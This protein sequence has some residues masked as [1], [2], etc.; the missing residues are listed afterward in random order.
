VWRLLVALM[1]CGC[2]RV[3]F[4]ARDDAGTRDTPL[5]DIPTDALDP[6]LVLWF[7]FNGS[8]NNVVNG[9]APQC[10]TAGQCPT[11]VPGKVGMAAQFDGIMQCLE[12][13]DDGSTDVQAFTLALWL[14]QP[15]NGEFA[16]FS[17]LYQP[18]TTVS[19]S[20]QIENHST[21]Q[22][23]FTTQNG[24]NKDTQLVAGPAPGAW[25]HVAMSFDG[26]TKLIYF[27]GAVAATEPQTIP[28]DYDTS[29]IVIGCDVNTNTFVYPY[30]GL[31]DDVRFYKRVLSAGEIAALAQ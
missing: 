13:A 25:H 4:D 30:A 22:Y 3:G 31:L 1:V 21:Q 19:D 20:W 6:S 23:G 15:A 18:I 17:K 29:A 9:A 14:N 7:P 16:L 11:Y 10:F 2:G 27:D 28:I 5:A 24:G 26:A 8:P 12:L